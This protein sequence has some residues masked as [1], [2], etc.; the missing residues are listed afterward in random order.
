M[1]KGYKAVLLFPKVLSHNFMINFDIRNND[2]LI[3]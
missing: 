3:F 2:Y 1:H